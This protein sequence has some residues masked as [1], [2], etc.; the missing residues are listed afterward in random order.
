[1][2]SAGSTDHSYGGGGNDTIF[3]DDGNT[4]IINCGKGTDEVRYDLALD[5][6]KA[7]ETK[8]AV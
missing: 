2:D 1:M 6:V 3:A 7:C 8:N 4:D 5:T